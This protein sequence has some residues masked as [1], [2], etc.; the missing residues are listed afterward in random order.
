MILVSKSIVGLAL[1]AVLGVSFNFSLNANAAESKALAEA[2]APS[3]LAKNDDAS[4]PVDDSEVGS[5]QL[6]VPTKAAKTAPCL[7]WL[8]PVD[9]K[10]R[11]ALLCI[12]GFS[13]H[14]GCYAAFGKEMAKNGI[15][16]YATDLRGFGELKDYNNREGMD[17][18]GDLV[19]IKATLQQIHKNHPGL[20][21]ILLGESLG[22]AI[23][24]RA[25]ALYPELISGL[26]CAVP[27]RDRFAMSDSEKKVTKTSV[28][29]TITGDYSKPMDGAAFAAVQ[30]ISANEELRSEWKN[31]PLMRTYFSAKDFVQFDFFM[32][33]N[34]EVAKFIK[35]MPV[36][37][38]Q[39]TA[40]KLIRPEGTWRLFERLATPNRQLVLSKN[41]E[42]L[43]F[44]ENQFRADDVGFVTTWIDKNVS[45]LDPAIAISMAKLPVVASMKEYSESEIAIASASPNTTS[46][47]TTTTT[48]NS[49]PVEKVATLPPPPQPTEF[50]H[51][52]ASQSPQINFWIE[53][54]RNGKVFRCNNKM[55]FKT[56][57]KIRFHLIPQSDGYAYLVMKAGTTGKSDVL[58]PNN[59][60]G[61]QNYL[62]RGKD[63]PIP[64]VGWMEFD[65]H[66]GTEQ[67][68]LVFASEKVDVTPESLK[69]R[70]MTAFVSADDTGSKDLCPT[71]MKLSWDDPKPVMLPDDFSA[72]AQVTN[73]NDSSLVRLM[74]SPGGMVSASISLLHGSNR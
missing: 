22:G 49:A 23:A 66:P 68:G 38:L 3:P 44:E 71:R 51:R 60:Y 21:V 63:Y 2:N 74:A 50:K 64:A 6:H 16:T 73:S 43:L 32:R 48:T 36:L 34:L 26:I 18:D 58:F 14:K 67:L 70:T 15:A 65:Q 46:T 1:G 17:F 10:P 25:A 5:K 19:D 56:G 13:L 52:L 69:N 12:H 20:P 30:K 72:V 47:S 39:G 31:D 62:F 57:D 40:D 61:T 24:L 33:G 27:A 42:H 8:P 45:P 55:E 28:L 35:D 11:V 53:L 9:V 59:Q 37:F 41:S 29:N 7:S 54:D 4:L